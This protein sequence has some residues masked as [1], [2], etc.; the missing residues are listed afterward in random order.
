MP[1]WISFWDSAHSIYVNARHRDVHYARIAEE[2]SHYV[3]SRHAVVLDYGCGEALHADIV[4]AA[5]GRLILSEAA[6]TL[7]IALAGRFIDNPK[8]EV[9]SPDHVV[10]LPDH[11]LDLVVMHSVA[12]YIPPVELDALFALFRRLLKGNGLFVLG[13][14]LRPEVSAFTDALA[15]LRFGAAQGFFLAALAGLVRTA[16]SDYRRLRSQI[17]LTRYAEAAMIEKLAAAG[18]SAQRA[19]KNIGHHTARM[20]FVARPIRGSPNT[21]PSSSSEYDTRDGCT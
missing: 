16:L 11:V 8:I 17:G 18:F 7:R 14:V 21:V 13:D 12:Q 9:R 6:P 15:L 19:P 5:A 4:A 20:T 10:A 2:I 3:P 1:D